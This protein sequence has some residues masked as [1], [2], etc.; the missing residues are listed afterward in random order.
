HRQ[1]ELP[2]PSVSEEQ[3]QVLRSARLFRHPGP[4]GKGEKVI[5]VPRESISKHTGP[6]KPDEGDPCAWCGGAQGPECGNRT[7]KIAQLQRTEH[8]DGLHVHRGP[9]RKG[10][11]NRTAPTARQNT[12]SGGIAADVTTISRIWT[13]SFRVV[14]RRLRQNPAVAAIQPRAAARATARAPASTPPITRARANTIA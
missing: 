13:G 12:A 1:V 4:S 7:E 9:H 2:R 14:C 5:D 6:G 3:R 10:T 11:R 8:T